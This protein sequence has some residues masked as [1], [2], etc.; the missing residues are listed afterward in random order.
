[1]RM[2][3]QGIHA[4]WTRR[5]WWQHGGGVSDPS[6]IATKLTTPYVVGDMPVI[7]MA[8]STP[9]CTLAAEWLRNVRNAHCFGEGAAGGEGTAGGLMGPG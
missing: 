9:V 8:T 3:M 5:G 7:T 6:S 1:M 2:M 4:T